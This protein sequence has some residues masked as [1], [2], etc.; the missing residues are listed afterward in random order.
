MK[1][2]EK[3]FEARSQIFVVLLAAAAAN[4]DGAFVFSHY[5]GIQDSRWRPNDRPKVGVGYHT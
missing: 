5:E 2:K 3:S 1:E 4:T